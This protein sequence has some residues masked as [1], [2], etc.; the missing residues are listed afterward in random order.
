MR[1]ETPIPQLLEHWD[2]SVVWTGHF[3]FRWFHTEE[4]R[5]EKSLIRPVVLNLGVWTH[6]YKISSSWILKL[7][8]V[9]KKN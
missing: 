3:S 9:F 4:T 8:H 7:L 6:Q 5:A 1:E 2:Q